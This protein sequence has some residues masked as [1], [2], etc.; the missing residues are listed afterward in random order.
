MLAASCDSSDERPEAASESPA[1]QAVWVLS[2]QPRPGDRVLELVVQEQACTGGKSPEGRIS[3]DV[4]QEA[5]RILV[6][7]RIQPLESKGAPC[8]PNPPTA[9]TVR[10]D[11]PV[12]TRAVL[13]GALRPPAVPSPPFPGFTAS[14]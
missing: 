5:E 7:V 12:G 14:P 9:Y 6:K 11:E 13:D 4:A 3:A 1:P 10:L 8:L 2:Q